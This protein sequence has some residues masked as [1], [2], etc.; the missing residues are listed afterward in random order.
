MNPRRL[1]CVLVITLFAG[2]VLPGELDAQHIHYRLIDIPTLGGP[3]AIGQVDGPGISQFIN[4]QGV[5][6]GGSDTSILD[7]NAPGCNNCFLVHAF[8]WKDG[9]LSDLGALPGVN[10]SH[11]ES[12]NAHGWATGGSFTSEFDPLKGQPAEHAVL[13][14]DGKINDLGTLDTGRESAALYVNNAGEVVGFSTF[15]TTPDPNSFLGAKIRAFIWRN[16][17]MRDVGTLGGLES[18]PAGGCDNQ[19]SGLVAGNSPTNATG[20]PIHAF[21]WENGKMTDIPTLGGTSAFAQC[22]NNQAQ[23]IGQSNLSGDTE[24]HAFLWEHGV[25]TD[26]G[27]LGG[28]FSNAF[29]LNNAGEAVGGATTTGDEEFHATLWKS[30]RI[31]DLNKDGD[32][33]SV[34]DAIN[35]SHQI[36]GNTFNCDT[37]YFTTVVWGENGSITDLNAAIPSNSSL[38]L[39]EPDNINDRGEIVGRGLP[40]G[41]DDLDTCGHVFLLIPCD[42]AGTEKCQSNTDSG[43]L[44]G[45]AAANTIATPPIQSPQMGRRLLEQLRARLAKQHHFPEIVRPRG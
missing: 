11:A 12:I 22:A 40:P 13:W 30:S 36:I 19:R 2:L 33:F 37:G 28:T 23:V 18:F 21:L 41:C 31:T 39:V 7:P 34:A 17:V 35:S 32:C 45:S 10:F 15:D 9:V 25:V 29:W 4:N 3:G 8:Q 26:L 6:V 38:F 43:A 16:G 27:T 5:V 24:Q 14:K 44:S 20:S 1:M 42:N